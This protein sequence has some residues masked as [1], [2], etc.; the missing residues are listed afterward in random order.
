MYNA[1]EAALNSVP[2]FSTCYVTRVPVASMPISMTANATRRNCTA[3][4]LFFGGIASENARN[5]ASAYTATIPAPDRGVA[6]QRSGVQYYPVRVAF[7]DGERDRLGALKL[8]PG[9]PVEGFIQTGYRTVFSYLTKP[10]A[11]NMAK[12]FREE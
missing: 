3:R 10:I 12:A 1:V 6:D 8:V 2:L 5:F 11:D 7:A 4:L 9:M